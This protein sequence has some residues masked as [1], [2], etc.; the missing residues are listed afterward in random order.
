MG[1][2]QTFAKHCFAL[3]RTH[4]KHPNCWRVIASD[5]L[6]FSKPDSI[7]QHHLLFFSS[8]N[9]RLEQLEHISDVNINW[10]RVIASYLINNKINNSVG[11]WTNALQKKKYCKMLEDLSTEFGNAKK[12]GGECLD[13]GYH[14]SILEDNWVHMWQNLFGSV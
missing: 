3:I 8:W 7:I 14:C 1:D 10:C 11:S 13:L 12:C 9:L 5:F 2:F 4:I 6:I